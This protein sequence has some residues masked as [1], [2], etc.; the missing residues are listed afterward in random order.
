MHA[1]VLRNKPVAV[2][3]MANSLRKGVKTLL[4]VFGCGTKRHLYRVPYRSR[5]PKTIS[6]FKRLVCLCCFGFRPVVKK[7]PKVPIPHDVFY[8]HVI[9]KKGPRHELTRDKTKPE[10]MEKPKT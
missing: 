4:G 8:L 5:L 9:S 3:G 1:C 2:V 7:G 6:T 10:G